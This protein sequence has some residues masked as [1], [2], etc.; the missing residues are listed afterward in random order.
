MTAEIGETLV[1]CPNC[2]GSGRAR[3]DVFG[4]AVPVTEWAGTGTADNRPIC[5]KCD[6]SGVIYKGVYS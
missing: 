4:K 5:R 3:Y 6:G 1:V 2:Q